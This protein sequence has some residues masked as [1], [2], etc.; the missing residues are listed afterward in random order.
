MCN[1]NQEPAKKKMKTIQFVQNFR[2]M[3]KTK[4]EKKNYSICNFMPL[5][6]WQATNPTGGAE[7]NKDKKSRHTWEE[8]LN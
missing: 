6:P 4:R 7:E 1:A 5:E 8:T 2:V 3:Q